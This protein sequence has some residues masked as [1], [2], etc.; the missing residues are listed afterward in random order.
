VSPIFITI[1]TTMLHG[2]APTGDVLS[3][4]Q[5]AETAAVAAAHAEGEATQDRDARIAFVFS[6]L[7]GGWYASPKGLNDSGSAC[8]TMQ[9]HV[10]EWASVLPAEWTCKA[11]RGDITLGMRAGLRILHFLEAKCGSMAAAIGSYAT[12]GACRADMRLVRTRCEMAGL[13]SKCEM[14]P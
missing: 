11:L 3:R 4:A 14:K 13:T 12:G 8:G 7:E 6:F 1:A 9:P 2:I 5:I 10:G